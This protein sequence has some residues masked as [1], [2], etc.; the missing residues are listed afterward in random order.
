MEILIHE[1]LHIVCVKDVPSAENL[2]PCQPILHL[3]MEF[4]SSIDIGIV[5]L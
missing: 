5:L 3:C 1:F 4:L 2:N